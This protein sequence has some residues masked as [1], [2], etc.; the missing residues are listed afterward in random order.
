M[1]KKL[2]QKHL[3]KGSQEFELVEDYVRIRTKAPFG[4]EEELR[5]MLSIVDPEP[6]ISKSHLHFN[7]RVNGEPLISLYLG[8]PNTEVFNEF[9]SALK[10]KAQEVFHAFAGLRPAAPPAGLAANVQDSP[11]ELED[12]APDQRTRIRRELDSA[13][14]AEAVQMLKLHLDEEEIKP[15]ISALEALEQ[16][17]KDEKLLSQAVNA[18]DGLG[19]RQGAV[20]TYAPYVSI[21]LSDDPFGW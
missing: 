1:S 12:S 18:F 16:D 2:I 13:R 20:L 15:M 3:V 9:V 7:S 19:P 4:R 11:P 8:K 5:V 6:V 10:Q 21:V 17:P 14:I